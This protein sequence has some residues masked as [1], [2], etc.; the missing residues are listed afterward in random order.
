MTREKILYVGVDVDDK[1]FHGAG[2][3]LL[4][5]EKFQF[6]CKPTSG[7]LIT[8]LRDFIKKGFKVK[9]CYESTYI[10][11]TL[12]RA[13]A[14][15]SIDCEIIASSLIP[16][17]S[18]KQVKTDR[19]DALKLAE[20]FGKGLLT[21]IHIPSEED[22]KVRDFIRSRNFMVKQRRHL[23]LHILGLCRRNGFN[24]REETGGKCH[25]TDTHERWLKSRISKCEDSV[26]QQNFNL[27]L[28]QYSLINSGI[29]S[30]DFEIEKM[31][32]KPKYKVAKNALNCFRGLST[33]SSMTLIAEIGDIR[34]FK[35]PKQLTS[36]AGFDIREYSSGGK[37]KRYG[38]T[39]M[40]NKQ[41]RT[42]SVESCQLASKPK[43]VS[44]RLALTRREQSFKIVDVADRCM[45]R[46]HKKSNRMHYA[47]KHTNVIKVACAREMLNFVWEVLYL[48]A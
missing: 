42:V 11:Y 10:G 18:G 12:Y 13:L 4:T 29:E 3:H 14:K 7:A 34:R 31:S 43:I 9:V 1:S 23:K 22:E 27:L 19:L 8:R 5:G 16:N 33:L 6:K 45:Q 25:W 21:A 48:V 2:L 26:L 38:I 32:E 41:I 40:G 35:H 46:L 15:V 37:S 39:K 47:G 20:Y 44:K 30:A 28:S 17:Q 24:F 36:F